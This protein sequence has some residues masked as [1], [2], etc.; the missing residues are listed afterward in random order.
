MNIFKWKP[1]IASIA[2]K[3]RRA[4]GAL[5]KLRHFV[6]TKILSNVYHA[7]FA[8]HFRYVSQI[9]GLCDNSVTHRIL[10]LQNFALRLL[11]FNGPRISATP[12]YSELKILKFFDQVKVMNI[13]YVHKYL[14]G[15]LPIDTLNTLNFEKIDHSFRTRGNTLSLLKLSNVKTTNYGLNSFSRLATIQWN[16]LQN[17][18]RNLKLSEIKIAKLKKLSISFFLNKYTEQ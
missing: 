13:I 8:L 4:N 17:R 3:L 6:P 7:I 18:I 14:N 1:H 5:S 12:L 2:T 16:C 9:F 10:T 11:T 15:N